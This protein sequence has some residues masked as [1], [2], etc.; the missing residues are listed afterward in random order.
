MGGGVQGLIRGFRGL[1]ALGSGFSAGAIRINFC[2]GSSG[3][4]S[5]VQEA[6]VA[7]RLFLD[8]KGGPT[9]CKDL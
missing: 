3:S 8:P 9:F 5:R 2:F 4:G 6:G 7:H 1:G